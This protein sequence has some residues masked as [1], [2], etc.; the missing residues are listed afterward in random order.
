M[1]QMQAQGLHNIVGGESWQDENSY[2]YTEYTIITADKIQV[3]DAAGNITVYGEA[4]DEDKKVIIKIDKIAPQISIAATTAEYIISNGTANMDNT[5]T[6]EED[7]LVSVEYTWTREKQEPETWVNS[8]S[9]EELA[10][11]T[12]SITKTATT[13]DEGT[14]YLYVKATD[15]V[16]HETIEN[17]DTLNVKVI[18][19]F[20]TTAENSAIDSVVQEN[21]V[22]YVLV[23]PGITAESLL[24]NLI[25]SYDLVIKRGDETIIESDEKLATN[26]TVNISY[27]Q[28]NIK[29]IITVKG[30]VTGDGKVEFSDILKLNQYR[31][32][33]IDD[34]T[35]A[36]FLAGNVVDSDSVITMSDIL[37]INQYRLGK[38]DTL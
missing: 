8:F 33:K 17:T 29:C 35:D 3:K 1:L 25:S 27:D 7:N 18:I 16:G 10:A 5:I 23:Q 36:E 6:I 13:D 11:K 12:A 31:L 22:Y 28:T 24:Q 21:D 32:N 38:I 34:F 4:N 14:W 20:N 15:I 30:D 26:D 37:K 19:S 2:T 9:E